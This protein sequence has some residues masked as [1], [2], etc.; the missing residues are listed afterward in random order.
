[1]KVDRKKLELAMARVCMDSKCL[2]ETSG[3]PRP[4]LNNAIAGKGIR[5]STLGRIAKA[6]GVEPADIME[7]EERQ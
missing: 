5:P 6:L 7:K 3:L 4:T 1:M 2:A